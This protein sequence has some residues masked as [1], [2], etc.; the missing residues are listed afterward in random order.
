MVWRKFPRDLRNRI[1]EYYE[2]R[3]QGK[4]FDEDAILSELSERLRL[5]N[6]TDE[7]NKKYLRRVSNIGVFLFFSLSICL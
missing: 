5:V 2:H 6:N 4:M 3:Y 7:N 1:T